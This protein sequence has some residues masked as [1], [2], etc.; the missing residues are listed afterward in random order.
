MAEAKQSS[1]G[2]G[3][4]YL[5]TLSIGEVPVALSPTSFTSLN[6]IEYLDR[7]LPYF[8]ITFNDAAGVLTHTLV[9]DSAW[10]TIKLMFANAMKPADKKW[11]TFRIYRRK[12]MSITG[13][14][15]AI[16]LTGFL[17]IPNM[18]SPRYERGWADKS[19]AVILRE[20]ME[21]LKLT[22]E[23]FDPDLD[24]TKISIVQPE[25]S[26]SLFLK[27]LSASLLS[28][29]KSSGF[30][31]FID[32][33]AQSA[34]SKTA[35]S[36]LVFRSLASLLEESNKYDFVYSGVPQKDALPIYSFQA[37]DNFEVLN[38]LGVG[39]QLYSY[40]DYENGEAVDAELGLTEAGFKSLAQ[41]YSYDPQI[42]T[43]GLRKFYGRT[44]A[45][46]SDYDAWIKGPYEKK[47]NT[48]GQLWVNT[49]GVTDIRCGDIVKVVFLANA[50]S[51]A[52]CQYSGYWLVLRIIHH[53]ADTYETRLLLTRSGVN[54]DVET[55]LTKATFVK[56]ALAG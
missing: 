46:E 3:G 39:K 18:F 25:W 12:P 32:S 47:V 2:L 49:M 36:R 40:F 55:R 27:Y 38:T 13:M 45:F 8:D 43:E 33:P 35:K 4:N 20:I 16:Q 6:I 24:K 48:L 42:G 37:V 50:K 9:L 7:P 23:D 26:N 53:F 31:S 44:N 1:I 34:T 54:T 21:D 5:L 29:E 56:G 10:N 22:E 11:M 28:K 51:L 15:S 19:V 52:S 41:Y 30:F 17:D 14:S